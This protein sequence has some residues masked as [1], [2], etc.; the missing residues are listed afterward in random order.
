[1]TPVPAARR[2]RVPGHRAL[3]PPRGPCQVRRTL[4][5]CPRAAR[6]DDPRPAALHGD[7]TRAGPGR[8]ET[9]VLLGG[10]ARVRVRGG[11]RRGHVGA[12][13]Q[14]DRRRPGQLRDGRRDRD[15]GA[16]RL[17]RLSL[18]A[19]QPPTYAARCSPVSVERAATRS[20]GLPSSLPRVLWSLDEHRGAFLV[21]FPP[22]RRRALVPE[23]TK[24]PCPGWSGGN[25]GWWAIQGL[26]L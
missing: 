12:G 1:M 24:T 2:S 10:G 22:I 19:G 23:T 3:Q 11:P 13:G 6:R 25:A 15:G 9:P 5:R 18:A 17:R 16:C 20:A 21:P 7:A 4:R 14:G 26:N 8:H